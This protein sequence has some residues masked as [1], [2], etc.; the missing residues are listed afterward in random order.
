MSRIHVMNADEH[1]VIVGFAGSTNGDMLGLPRRDRWRVRRRQV[2]DGHLVARLP[3][4]LT[5]VADRDE[6]GAVRRD[7]DLADAQTAPV[8]RAENGRLRVGSTAPVDRVE[9][10]E[11]SPSGPSD[12]LEL[13]GD[14]QPR[15]RTTRSSTAALG[16]GRK[17]ATVWPFASREPNETPVRPLFAVHRVERAADEH[18]LAVRSRRERF[19]VPLSCG[20]KV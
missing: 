15:P 18:G 7:V 1:H 6:L 3:A 4:Q 20:T 19:D 13:S 2:D 12:G 8:L 14:V 9:S 17:P 11:G 5:E 10:R 16:L